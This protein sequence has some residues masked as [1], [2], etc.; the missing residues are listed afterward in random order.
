MNDSEYKARDQL[1][2][3]GY[4]YV[5]K[6]GGSFGDFDLLAFGPDKEMMRAIQV[7][8]TKKQ[9][10]F[11]K[12]KQQI[13]EFEAPSF[14]SKELWIWYSHRPTVIRKRIENFKGWK[15]HLLNDALADKLKNT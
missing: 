9:L 11:E 12:L 8:S 6:A 2:E 15:I 13:R 7:K 10:R 5:M 4:T 14:I 1:K 3:E